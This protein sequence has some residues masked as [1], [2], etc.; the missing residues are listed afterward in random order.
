MRTEASRTEQQRAGARF[1]FAHSCARYLELVDDERIAVAE[2]SLWEMLEWE[3]LD[4][5]RIMDTGSES[6]PFSLAARNLAPAVHSF[7]Y[8]P[9]SVGCTQALCGC[10]RT[11]DEGCIIEGGDVLDEDCLDKLAIFDVVYSW[12]MLHHTVDM[13]RALA[14]MF[15]LV[16]EGGQL[17]VA[18]YNDQRW[19]SK[20]WIRVKLT[21][22]KGEL[23][24]SAIIAVHAPYFLA[25]HTVKW[26]VSSSSQK[27]RGMDPR[28]DILDWLGGYPFVVA[29]PEAVLAF[30]LQH[31]YTLNRMT[32]VDG[33][34]GCNE[35]VFRAP[36]VD[37]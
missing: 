15:S 27:K 12:G 34:H 28:R 29:R 20:C 10:Y 23:E 11:G 8:D 1:D 35:F 14:N 6:G 22:I 5:L 16:N 7:G 25:R 18:L 13:W 9:E 37:R 31:C 36:S 19:L 3:A 32:T 17:F 33:H 24:R 30:Y 26:V 4:G 21:Y 2:Q